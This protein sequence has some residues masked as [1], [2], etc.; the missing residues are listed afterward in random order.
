MLIP[1][2]RNRGEFNDETNMVSSSSFAWRI[3]MGWR[4]NGRL[5]RI[6]H[7]REQLWHWRH[8]NNE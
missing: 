7:W 1:N 8:N 3:R 5:D 2:I 4:S 6:R